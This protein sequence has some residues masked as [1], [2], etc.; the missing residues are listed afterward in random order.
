MVRIRV[1]WR[2]SDR[3]RGAARKRVT[4]GEA[5]DELQVALHH[6]AA[7]SVLLYTRKIS[8]V[9]SD[10]YGSDGTANVI[11]I[12]IGSISTSNTGVSI[13]NEK[14][15]QSTHSNVTFVY[16]ACCRIAVKA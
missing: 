16:I 12:K 8:D 9:R 2:S 4:T 7:R 13:W 6:F 1:G 3:T 14:Y 11:L 10:E 5:G 15:N